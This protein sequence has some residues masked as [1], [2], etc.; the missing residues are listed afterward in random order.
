MEP[1]LHPLSCAWDLP[2]LGARLAIH[3]MAIAILIGLT[4]LVLTVMTHRHH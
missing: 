4:A 1:L 2:S 3:T